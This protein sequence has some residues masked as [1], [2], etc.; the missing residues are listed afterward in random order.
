MIASVKYVGTLENTVLEARIPSQSWQVCRE[1]KSCFSAH[2][3]KF[4]T[5]NNSKFLFPIPN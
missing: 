2:S 1:K 4:K 5:I 3:F